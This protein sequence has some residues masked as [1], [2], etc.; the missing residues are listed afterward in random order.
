MRAA[1]FFIAVAFALVAVPPV[2]ADDYPTL[3]RVDHVLRCMKRE[4]GQTID[5]LYA[6]SCEIDAIAQQ[7]SFEEFTE[8]LTFEEYRRMPGEKGGM[9]RDSERGERLIAAL[10][11]AREEAR[12]RCFVGRPPRAS[13]R[14]G[15]SGGAG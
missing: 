8:A 5:N 1:A 11:K 15:A 2:H 6:C 4:G 12:K 14:G 9:F 13:G 3:E 7:M 10:E